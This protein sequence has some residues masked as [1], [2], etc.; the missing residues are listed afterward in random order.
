MSRAQ[1]RKM[2]GVVG[3]LVLG[4]ALRAAIAQSAAATPNA[5]SADTKASARADGEPDGRD[6][7]ANEVAA[8]TRL[9]RGCVAAAAPSLWCPIVSSFRASH[10]APT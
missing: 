4:V 1:S 10:D 6:E 5:P 2:I 9:F 7:R 3:L 8:F